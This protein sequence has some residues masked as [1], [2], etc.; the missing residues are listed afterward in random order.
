MQSV[1]TG[2]IALLVAALAGGSGIDLQQPHRAGE[3]R[4]SR[5]AAEVV[6]PAEGLKDVLRP[7]VDRLGR[8]VRC[9]AYQSRSICQIS[10]V[11]HDVNRIEIYLHQVQY[12]VHRADLGIT[13]H[14]PGQAGDIE[15]LGLRKQRLNQVAAGTTQNGSLDRRREGQKQRARQAAL[16]MAEVKDILRIE[17]DRIGYAADRRR[18]A[19]HCLDQSHQLK[20]VRCALD[21]VVLGRLWIE[22][23]E[24]QHIRIERRRSSPIA[25]L[26]GLDAQYRKMYCLR[27]RAQLNLYL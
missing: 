8:N 11:V 1:V 24:I 9:F 23:I 15:R 20:I 7:G 17:N 19:V 16:G 10:P 26:D 2:Q 27:S 18:Q 21:R 14:Q 3:S 4:Q 25:V 12:R 22:Q 13:Q 6:V 5:F